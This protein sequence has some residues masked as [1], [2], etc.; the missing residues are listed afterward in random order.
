M[1]RAWSLP[2]R[3]EPRVRPPKE[4]DLAIDAVHDVG[5]RHLID[6]RRDVAQHLHMGGD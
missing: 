3:V 5:L 1:L 4:N 6:E 2:R